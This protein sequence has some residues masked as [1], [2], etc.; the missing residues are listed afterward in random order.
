M[1][2]QRRKKEIESEQFYQSNRINGENSNHVKQFIG[3]KQKIWNLKEYSETNI[4][5][6]IELPKIKSDNPE[7][8]IKVEKETTNKFI[9]EAGNIWNRERFIENSGELNIDIDENKGVLKVES[10]EEEMY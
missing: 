5:C 1:I 2:F 10:S 9:D 3:S 6:E 8:C 7:K 4:E